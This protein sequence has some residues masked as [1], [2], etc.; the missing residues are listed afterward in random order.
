MFFRIVGAVS[1]L[2]QRVST[3]QTLVNPFSDDGLWVDPSNT[4]DRTSVDLN[5]LIEELNHLIEFRVCV[6]ISLRIL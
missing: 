1:S 5:R 3:I 6:H 2:K 4:L